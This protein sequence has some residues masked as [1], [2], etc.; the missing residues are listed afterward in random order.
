MG[1][2]GQLC[3]FRHLDLQNIQRLH[4]LASSAKFSIFYLLLLQQTGVT[5]PFFNKILNKL[6]YLGTFGIRLWNN[7]AFGMSLVLKLVSIYSALFTP[8]HLL[9]PMYYFTCWTECKGIISSSF[10]SIL[11]NIVQYNTALWKFK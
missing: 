5:K 8:F 7:L 3:M 2:N 1:C 4:S 10:S 9:L 11:T 6:S